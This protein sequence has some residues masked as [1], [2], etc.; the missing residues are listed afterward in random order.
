MIST[1]AYEPNARIRSFEL[2]AQ[3]FGLAESTPP[4]SE[5]QAARL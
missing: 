5:G 3:A 4:R 2:V 1:H